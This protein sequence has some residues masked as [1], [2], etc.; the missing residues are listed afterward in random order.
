MIHVKLA[1]NNKICVQVAQ[2]NLY[3]YIIIHVKIYVQWDILNKIKNV[4][5]VKEEL[6]ILNKINQNVW[7]VLL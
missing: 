5:S 6:I 2:I 7:I 3:F 4:K 1:I